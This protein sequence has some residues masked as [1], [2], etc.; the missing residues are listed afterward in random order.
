MKKKDKGFTINGN[1]TYLLGYVTFFQHIVTLL[2][3]GGKCLQKHVLIV[4]CMIPK[5]CLNI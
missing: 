2:N 3:Q 4:D 5:C 1:K